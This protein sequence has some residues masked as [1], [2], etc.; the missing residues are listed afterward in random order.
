M[1]G[2]LALSQA[3]KLARLKGRPREVVLEAYEGREAGPEPFT[4]VHYTVNVIEQRMA[5]GIAEA[6]AAIEEQK[7]KEDVDD[8]S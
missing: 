7:A 8:R 3:D 5:S 2:L 4:W 1:Q 6:D